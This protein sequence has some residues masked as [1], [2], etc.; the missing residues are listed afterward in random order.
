MNMSLLSFLFKCCS[1]FFERRVM[2]MTIAA[3]RR[4]N[5]MMEMINQV[6]I[7]DGISCCS[8]ASICDSEIKLSCDDITGSD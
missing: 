4:M 3:V 7:E 1:Y 8:E 5:K 6:L 2:M